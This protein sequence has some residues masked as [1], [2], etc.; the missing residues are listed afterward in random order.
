M[1]GLNLNCLRRIEGRT[2]DV[3]KTP[4]GKS[5]GGTFWTLLS[6]SVEGIKQFQVMQ[7]KIQGVTFNLV[8]DTNF[9][10]DYFQVLLK[11]IQQHCG[12][13]FEVEFQIVDEI[14]LTK[15]GK[16]RFVISNLT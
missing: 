1:C 6:R 4:S 9:K 13:D 10:T 11:K 7:E 12:S 15:S 3:I 2:F 8:P 14:P 16:F 5:L